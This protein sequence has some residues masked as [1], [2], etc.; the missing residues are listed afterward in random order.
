M[1]LKIAEGLHRIQKEEKGFTLV[2]LLV[3]IAI[4]GVIAAIAIPVIASR[5]DEARESANVSNIRQ[6]Q[7]AVDLFK[8]DTGIYPYGSNDIE[9]AQAW[10]AMLT[11]D[12]EGDVAAA[13]GEAEHTEAFFEDTD[14]AG[15]YLRE[16]VEPPTG[17]DDYEIDANTGD[18]T[19]E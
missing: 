13:A 1:V 18:V 5:I 16:V 4:L 2:E 11:A 15:P 17:Y 3:V 9:N 7:S 10:Q 6:L 14:W 8:L 12:S 19:N